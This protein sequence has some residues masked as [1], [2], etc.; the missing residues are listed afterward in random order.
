MDVD[1]KGYIDVTDLQRV[2]SDLGE[3]MQEDELEEMI[4]RAATSK[5]EGGRVTLAD[6]EAVLHQKLFA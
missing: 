6:L 3:R 2:A 1:D 4:Q 5:P